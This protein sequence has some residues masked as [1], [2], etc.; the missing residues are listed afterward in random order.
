MS[1]V[2]SRKSGCSINVLMIN[3]QGIIISDGGQD[4]FLSYNRIPL[5]RGASINPTELVEA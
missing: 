4:F 2:F 1:P 3:G 5:M